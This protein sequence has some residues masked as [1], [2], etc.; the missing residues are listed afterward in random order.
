MKNRELP[1]SIEEFAWREE[2]PRRRKSRS[3]Q[4][5]ESPPEEVAGDGAGAAGG[6]LEERG[7]RGWKKGSNDPFTPMLPC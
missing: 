1:S 7:D 3:G 2:F 4:E 6:G 5:P